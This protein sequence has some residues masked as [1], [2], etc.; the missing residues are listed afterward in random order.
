MLLLLTRLQSDIA[1][2]A[3][4]RNDVPRGESGE[5]GNKDIHIARV[6]LTPSLDSPWQND[7]YVQQ[8]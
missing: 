1:V 7:R 8:L 6:D 3:Y 4:L 5:M 2:S